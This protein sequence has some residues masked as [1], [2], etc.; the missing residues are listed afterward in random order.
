MRV[1]PVADADVVGVASEPVY[2]VR[3]WTPGGRPGAAWMVDE[4]DV[5]EA[6]DV[7]SVLSW[8]RSKSHDG[9]FEVLVPCPERARARDGHWED[10]KTFVRVFGQPA[11][12]GGTTEVVLLHTDGLPQH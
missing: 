7:L 5:H 12:E 6:D 4:Y 2:R 3:V 9:S 1:V 8:A 11:D 10:V